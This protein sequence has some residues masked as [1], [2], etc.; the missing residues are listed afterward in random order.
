VLLWLVEQSPQLQFLSFR[1]K[2]EIFYG[3]INLAAKKI[4]RIA[5]NDIDVLFAKG[6]IGILLHKQQSTF[7]SFIELKS[8]GLLYE[9]P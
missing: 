8:F 7:P 1:P 9:Y 4:P 3:A 2:G 5:R 6:S